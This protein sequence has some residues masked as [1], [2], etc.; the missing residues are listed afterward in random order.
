M[1]SAGEP[2]YLRPAVLIRAAVGLMFVVYLR[3]ITFDFVYDDHLQISL[4][5]WLESWRQVP[6][7][8]THQLWAFT[9][10]HSPA[11]YYRPLFMVWLATVKH[12]TGGAPG[13]YHMATVLLHLVVVVEAYALAR[14]LVK[15][16]L[17]AVF[18]AAMWGLHPA[19]I[20]AVAWISGGGEP[21]VAAFFFGTFIAYLKGE[22]ESGWRWKAAA[23][24]SFA[25]ALL[26]K[27]QAVVVPVILLAYEWVRGRGQDLAA[28]ARRAAMALVPFALVGATFWGIRW[29][30]MHGFAEA[31]NG[32]SVTKTLLSQPMTWWWYLRH[33]LSP[34]S[35]SLFYPELIA[36]QF[37]VH[38]VLFPAAF[39]LVL[40]IA[41]WT[42]VRKSAEGVLLYAWFVCTMVPP[43]AMVLLLQPHDRYLYLPSFAVA[44]GFAVVIRALTERPPVQVIVVAVICV[45]FAVS[46]FFQLRPWD[47]DVALM[48]NAVAHAPDN[49]Q[50]RVILAIAYTQQNDVGRGTA[51]LREAARRNP[52]NMDM[53]Q[54]LAMQEYTVG[55]YEAAYEDFKH[56]LATALPGREGVSLYNLGLI[57]FRLGRLQ[58]AEDWTRKAI[59][60]DSQAPG[61]HRSLAVILDAQGRHAESDTERKLA[62]RLQK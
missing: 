21:L 58:E 48:Q 37:S 50:A 16:E 45:A 4:N 42:Q 44:V 35:L 47:N 22:Q 5:P 46:T 25:L 2:W 3:T 49:T 56:A 17:T 18:A 10:V 51:E 20:E 62:R 30:V 29:H 52:N 59:A 39:V 36:R 7:Y 15:D 9:D 11:R 31:E 34:F 43:V 54:A 19:K 26:S 12:V 28:R 57:S 6:Q 24:A 41:L 32:I 33:M 55:Q 60:V 1:A 53:W 23:L 61:Y 13:W 27:E 38:A 8:F 40:A 14:L